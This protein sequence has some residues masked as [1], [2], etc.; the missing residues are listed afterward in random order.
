V[1]AELAQRQQAMIDGRFKPFAAPLID[2]QGRSRLARGA[3][4]DAQIASMDWL[5]QGV[6]GTLPASR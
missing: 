4:D 1:K 3:L 6:M 2:N 5:I